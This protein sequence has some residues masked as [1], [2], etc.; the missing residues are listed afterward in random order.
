MR[1][2]SQIEPKFWLSDT[3]KEIISSG[4]KPTMLAFYFMTCPSSHA[5]GIFYCPIYLIA[6]ETQLPVDD[7]T[8]CIDELEKVSF[9]KYDTQNDL[10]WIINMGAYQANLTSKTDK[11]YKNSIKHIQQLPA[12][13]LIYEF[14]DYYG[15]DEAEILTGKLKVMKGHS[16]GLHKRHSKGEATI[17]EGSVQSSTVHDVVLPKIPKTE[18]PEKRADL[19]LLGEVSNG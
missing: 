4:S 12:C 9:I 7:V 14:A 15:I 5:C 3:G 2:F 1:T 8:S 11:K 6:S 10:A 19:D 18:N 17:A 16:K 13:D